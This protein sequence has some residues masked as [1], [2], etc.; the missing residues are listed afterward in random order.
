M[1]FYHIILTIGKH[2]IQYIF[3]KELLGTNISSVMRK[4]V[5]KVSD[6]F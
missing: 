3:K 2:E 5:F 6:Q 4:P 1:D